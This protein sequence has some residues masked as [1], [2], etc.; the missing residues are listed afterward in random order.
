M[1]REDKS[2]L[3]T[4]L[5]LIATIGALG[6]L[7]SGC[8]NSNDSKLGPTNKKGEARQSGASNR[9][10]RSAEEVKPLPVGTQA[11]KMT[12]RNSQGKPVDL[13]QA[14]GK[15]PTLLVFY[16]GGW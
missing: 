1:G 13:H 9:I 15:A 4:R 7:L 16:R 3:T 2:M 14:L 12:V 10:P 11:P 5:P 6:I 8:D